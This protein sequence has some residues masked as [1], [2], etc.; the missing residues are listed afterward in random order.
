VTVNPLHT[1]PEHRATT[2]ATATHRWFD[3]LNPSPDM[4]SLTD[5]AMGLERI[6]RWSGQTVGYAPTVLAHSLHVHEVACSM[7]AGWQVR[8]CALLHDAHEAYVGDVTSPVK[9]AMRQVWASYHDHPSSG[10]VLGGLPDPW[11]LIEAK[12][13][14]AVLD[15]FHLTDAFYDPATADVVRRADLA[16][17]GYEADMLYGDGTAE[18]WG[19]PKAPGPHRTSPQGSVFRFRSLAVTYTGVND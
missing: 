3:V 17:L 2:M 10:S 16:V 1:L 11:T 9:A 12:A 8:A 14:A 4:V 6:R 13:Q 19:L 15:H 5:I 18:A 7:S